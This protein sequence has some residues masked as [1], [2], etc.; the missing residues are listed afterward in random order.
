MQLLVT[1]RL[2]AAELPG[3]LSTSSRSP[4]PGGGTHPGSSS[5][6]TWRLETTWSVGRPGGE[7]DPP[8]ACLPAALLQEMPAPQP[9]PVPAGGQASP[10]HPSQSWEEKETSRPGVDRR[11]D[12]R[13]GSNVRANTLREGAARLPVYQQ[14]A[15]VSIPLASRKTHGE[16]EPGGRRTH[17]ICNEVSPQAWRWGEGCR[18]PWRG[19]GGEL[20]RGPC[21]CKGEKRPR[22]NAQLRQGPPNEEGRGSTCRPRARPQPDWF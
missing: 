3:P 8:A 20:E 18:K 9:R 5:H 6:L 22:Q 13:K 7:Q 15:Q 16:Q 4:L 12:G 11:R 21:S 19:E 17:S 14:G 2:Q 1:R 10:G